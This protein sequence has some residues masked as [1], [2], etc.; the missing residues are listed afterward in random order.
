MA[1]IANAGTHSNE[2]HRP[3]PLEPLSTK[4]DEPLVSISVAEMID[5]NCKACLPT[6]P[7]ETL[8]PAHGATANQECPLEIHSYCA[9][10]NLPLVLVC[11]FII[12][13]LILKNNF[14]TTQRAK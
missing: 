5:N 14:M 2:A 1:G 13:N 11:S 8:E 9:I 6:P 10:K 7:L 3:H 4:L 12:A